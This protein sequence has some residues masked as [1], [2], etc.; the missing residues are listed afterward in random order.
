MLER[1]SCGALKVT[2]Y[3]YYVLYCVANYMFVKVVIHILLLQYLEA[4]YTKI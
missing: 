1:V 2:L 4:G 3:V